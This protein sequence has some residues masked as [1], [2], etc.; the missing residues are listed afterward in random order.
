MA[1]AAQDKSDIDVLKNDLAA[2]RRDLASLVEHIKSGAAEGAA[3]QATSQLGDEAL[4]LYNKLAAE[5]ARS[6][7]ALGSKVEEQPVTSLLIAFPAGF[8][9]G[10]R[11]L[12]PTRAARPPP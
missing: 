11:S 8:I 3:R 5:G 1:A 10:A 4:P 6:V 12:P 2:L 7:Q 9:A